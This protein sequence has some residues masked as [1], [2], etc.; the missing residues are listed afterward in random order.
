MVAIP[1]RLPARRKRNDVMV[2][3]DVMISTTLPYFFANTSGRVNTFSLW[4]CLARNNPLRISES[5]R[6][7]GNTAPSKKWYL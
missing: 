6:P 2:E 3:R 4:M 1:T 5:P 7:I